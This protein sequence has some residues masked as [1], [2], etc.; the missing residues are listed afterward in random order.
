MRRNLR[1][2][3]LMTAF[4]GV[5]IAALP[6]IAYAGGDYIWSRQ[7]E[8]FGA[9]TL[10]M[11]SATWNTT[12]R[13]DELRTN[14]DHYHRDA[15]LDRVSTGPYYNVYRSDAGHNHAYDLHRTNYHWETAGSHY[16]RAHSTAR[17]YYSY[18][19]HVI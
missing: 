12:H 17:W 10:R 14:S 7:L 13:D 1:V 6:S 2:K 3:L 18:E 19:Y 4:V 16:I 9:I 8:M 15:Y 5:M 11:E